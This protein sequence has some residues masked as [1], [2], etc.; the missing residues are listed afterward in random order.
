MA[1]VKQLLILRA[2]KRITE[3]TLQD[4]RAT[5]GEL[6][7]NTEPIAILPKAWAD[8]QAPSHIGFTLEGLKLATLEKLKKWEGDHPTSTVLDLGTKECPDV[9]TSLASVGLRIHPLA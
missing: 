4:L 6:I 9:E 5:F 7:T 8:K 2:P 3:D 1:T